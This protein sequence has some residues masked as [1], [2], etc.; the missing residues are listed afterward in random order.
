MTDNKKADVGDPGLPRNEAEA[1]HAFQG[2]QLKKLVANRHKGGWQTISLDKLVERAEQEMQEMYKALSAYKTARGTPGFDT[3][4]ERIKS[5]ELEIARAN[6]A[7]ECADVANFLL[8]IAD[9]T[10][11]LAKP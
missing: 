11:G 7:E 6:L 2:L 4:A 9:V 1:L 8:M 10:G 5:R 3:E